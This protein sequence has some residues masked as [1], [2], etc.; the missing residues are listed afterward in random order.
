MSQ[1]MSRRNFI[2]AAGAAAA[3]AGVSLTPMAGLLSKVSAQ[4]LPFVSLRWIY[5]GQPPEDLKLVQDALNVILKEKIN[6]EIIM[7]ATDWGAFNDKMALINAGGEVYD[8]SYTASWINNYFSNVDNEY[9]A[10]LDDLLLEFA[11]GLWD[12]MP[13]TTWG[14]ARIRG[15]IYGIINQQIFPRPQ[16]FQ[17]RR[18]IIDKLDLSETI[19]TMTSYDELTGLLQ[20]IKEYVDSGEDPNLEYAAYLGFGITIGTWDNENLFGL[21]VKGDDLEHRQAVI[22]SGTEDFRK[23]AEMVYGWS[24]A[25]YLPP[26]RLSPE[27]VRANLR[28]GKYAMT[29]SGTIKPGGEVESEALLGFPVRDKILY[30]PI[31]TT[32]AVT[33]TLT[34]ISSN[35]PN[36]ER[37]MMFL[38]LMNTNKEVYNLFCK[39]I[40]GTHWEW[41]DETIELIRP[42]APATEWAEVK[43]NP[44]TD[45]QFGN[46]FNAYIID[47]AQVGVWEATYDL[48]TETPPSPLLG[49]TFDAANVQTE[50]AALTSLGTEYGE[51]LANGVVDPDDPERGIAAFQ[52][53][54][55]DAGI[56]RVLAEAQRQIDEWV[57]ANA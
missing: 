15:S 47:R 30:N 37:A 25:G 32:P 19:D 36:P 29:I 44:N 4:D 28:A 7:E 18:D 23:R 50:A 13:E 56:E 12:S 34:G 16:G 48:N 6:A 27:D 8:I 41:E 57:A 10:A 3:A 5:G 55:I 43:Y 21:A 2:R 42:A 39:G 45:W 14:A 31:L 40:Q 38:E 20:T 46:Q 22:F 9:L 1:K 49:F 54:E 33:A 53:R 24:Q 26:D 51:P 11:P 52:Q 35:S 17:I